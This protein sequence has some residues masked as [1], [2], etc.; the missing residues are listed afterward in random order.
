MPK[1][2]KSKGDERGRMRGAVAAP[3]DGPVRQEEADQLFACFGAFDVVYLAVSGGA[4]SLALMHLAADWREAEAL[5]R[6]GCAAA[7]APHESGGP[8]E[9]RVLTVDHGLR[10]EAREEAAFVMAQAGSRGLGG[11]IL[12][13]DAP[14]PRTGIQEWARDK[15]YDVLCARVA[16][17]GRRAGLVTAHH[18]GDL[19]ETMLMRLARG[20][21]LDGLAGIAEV[22]ERAG[23]PLLRPLL[24][25]EKVRLVAT[26]V[27]RNVRWIEDPSNASATFE[28]V[29]LRQ[30]GGQRAA[31]GL[32]DRALA[33]TARRLRRAREALEA[34]TDLM[35]DVSLGRARLETAGVFEWPWQPGDLPDEIAIR[36]LMRTLIGIGGTRGRLRLARVE[37]LYDEIR[38]PRFSG[39]TLGH[40]VIRPPLHPPAESAAGPAA[41]LEI[42]REP[43]RERLPVIVSDLEAPLV[44]DNRFLVERTAAARGTA[45]VRAFARD[46]LLEII[47][48]DQAAAVPAD[49]ALRA[50]PVIEDTAGALAIPALG[51]HRA[52]AD[53]CRPAGSPY[54]ARFLS[55]RL[56]GDTLARGAME[57]SG[58][59]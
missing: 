44:W 5:V 4:D 48:A 7:A 34:V 3:V 45:T 53:D 47:G 26:L 36:L 15:R 10:E 1:L 28:R 56:R 6:D 35:A 12:R 42:Y 11:E 57:P 46:D 41:V 32:E 8:P 31:L 37:R 14:P 2:T 27:A 9:L 22:S 13:V 54:R 43:D 20:S 50:T 58:R 38:S 55:E 49:D 40:C 24:G 30:L 18:E 21:G 39:A 16:R 51:L 33:T 23:V 52:R 17:D 29:R 25:V 19:A 59:S